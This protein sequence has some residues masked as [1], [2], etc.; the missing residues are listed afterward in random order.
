M[1][2]VR[3]KMTLDLAGRYFKHAGRRDAVAREVLGFTPWRFSQ[4]VNDLL[5]RPDALAYSPQTV[6]RLQRLREARRVAR[7]AS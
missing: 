1:L 6:R 2:T 4:V 7:R 3:E 5:D